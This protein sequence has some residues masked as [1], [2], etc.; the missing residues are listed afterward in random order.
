MYL[1]FF[2]ALSIMSAGG[3][4]FCVYF[5]V[6]VCIKEICLNTE[7]NSSIAMIRNVSEQKLFPF[8][9]LAI[10]LKLLIILLT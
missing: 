9:T 4:D 3:Y 1:Y 2:P 8:L 6:A 7:K 5:H 10:L